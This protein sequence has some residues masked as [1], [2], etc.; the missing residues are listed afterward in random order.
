MSWGGL[1]G[2][3][4]WLESEEKEAMMLGGFAEEVN[5]GWLRSTPSHIPLLDIRR[6]HEPTHNRIYSL[7]V[8]IFNVSRPT[9][10]DADALI[11]R[12]IKLL[13]CKCFSETD[14]KFCKDKNECVKVE[15]Q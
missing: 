2:W 13:S 11:P 7:G 4:Y 12:G 14:K 5:S 3:I 15:A 1:P 6:W 9:T 10:T 8:N